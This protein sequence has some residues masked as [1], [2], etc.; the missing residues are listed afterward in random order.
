MYNRHAVIFSY[1]LVVSN[2]QNCSNNLQTVAIFNIKF[3]IAAE[4]VNQLSFLD[5]SIT[6]YGE[7]FL[8][9]IY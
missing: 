1:Y 6:K 5:V 3:T 2:K 8:T 4:K 9:R 7:S